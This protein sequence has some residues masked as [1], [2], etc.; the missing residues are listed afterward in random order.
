M[1]KHAA[2]GK[3]S[4]SLGLSDEHLRLVVQDDGR[5]P[6]CEVPESYKGYGIAGLRERVELCGG[7]L[8]F[9]AAERRGS[10]L[11]VEIPVATVLRSSG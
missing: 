10:E 6:Q 2:A 4:L 3:A 8:T 1:Q 11:R 5:G 7:H 9:E